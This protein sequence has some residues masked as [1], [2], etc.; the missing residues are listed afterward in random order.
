MHVFITIELQVGKRKDKRKIEKQA[1]REGGG[2][3]KAKEVLLALHST[4]RK[5]AAFICLSLTATIAPTTKKYKPRKRIEISTYEQ[6][7]TLP[8]YHFFHSLILI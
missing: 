6:K 5:G 8:S 2:G 3:E 1:E 7:H 4:L